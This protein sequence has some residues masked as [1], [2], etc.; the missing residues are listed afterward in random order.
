MLY[1]NICFLLEVLAVSAA[2]QEVLI[3]VDG[4]VVPPPPPAPK[5]FSLWSSFVGA[6][7]FLSLSGLLRSSAACGA[8]CR[9]L[10]GAAAKMR[11]KQNADG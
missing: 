7:S 5:S 1:G 4:A 9:L 8:C 2:R 10:T 3:S 6:S 11:K